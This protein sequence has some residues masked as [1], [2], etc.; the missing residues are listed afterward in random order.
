M[1]D[2]V[3]RGCVISGRSVAVACAFNYGETDFDTGAGGYPVWIG[4]MVPEMVSGFEVASSDVIP[5]RA[6]DML[7]LSR[8]VARSP[9]LPL[10]GLYR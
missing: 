10:A 4:A 5:G 2:I 1:Y 9:Y 6:A 8:R 3:A 7:H